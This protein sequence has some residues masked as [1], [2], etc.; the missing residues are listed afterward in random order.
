MIWFMA[1]K[2]FYGTLQNAVVVSNKKFQCPNLMNL[3]WISNP[4]KN[5]FQLSAGLNLKN[6]Y[7]FKWNQPYLSRSS[8][9]LNS[10]SVVKLIV[11]LAFQDRSFDSNFNIFWS[12]FSVFVT[13]SNS[14]DFIM[15]AH[16]MV[17]FIIDVLC[18]TVLYYYVF[19][20]KIKKRVVP[21]PFL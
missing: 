8:N 12:F 7:N 15:H 18:F 4:P 3:S 6:E 20:Y 1:E 14:A 9:S 10:A 21:V 19:F 5:R 17:N 2:T 16:F 11:D 13:L